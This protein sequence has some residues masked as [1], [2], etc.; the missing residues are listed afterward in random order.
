LE[1]PREEIVSRDPRT[2]AA[3]SPGDGASSSVLLEL[4]QH[5][6]AVEVEEAALVGD[7]VEAGVLDRVVRA[8]VADLAAACATTAGC[9]RT[10]GQVTAVCTGSD[11]ASESAPSTDQ[12]N[13]LWPWASFHGW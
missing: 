11:T 13:G 1:R 9:V 10:V 8:V 3:R 7:G 2:A 12:A 6:G 4:R 5:P